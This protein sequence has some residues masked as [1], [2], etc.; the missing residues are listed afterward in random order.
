MKTI[1]YLKIVEKSYLTPTEYAEKYSISV[2]A[3][4]WQ[5]EKGKRDCVYFK[6]KMLIKDEKEAK[7][8]AK[9]DHAP[10]YP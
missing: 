3:V 5:I 8:L 7:K 10:P 1:S 6:G 2:R 4:Y 9:Y